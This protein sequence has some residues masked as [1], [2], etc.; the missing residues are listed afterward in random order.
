M[1]PHLSQKA[2]MIAFNTALILALAYSPASKV[3][4][5]TTLSAEV[6]Q[7]IGSSPSYVWIPD[8]YT[9]IQEAISN[10]QNDSVI[11][12]RK[13]TYN[14][15]IFID[16]PV[17]I[18]GEGIETIIDGNQ[19]DNVV[20][21]E[22][23]RV[24]LNQ[25]TI[26]NSAKDLNLQRNS[27]VFIK[28]SECTIINV[29]FTD[30]AIGLTLA[31]ACNTVVKQCIFAQN[32]YGAWLN[33]SHNNNF[34]HNVFSE[35]DQSI[36]QVV[37]NNNVFA[38][39]TMENNRMGIVLGYSTNNTITSNIICNNYYAIEFINNP[40]GN[41]L[42]QGNNISRNIWAL[43][44][45]SANYER[46][47][48]NTIEENSYGI[49][50]I[51]SNDNQIW[52]N[53]IINNAIQTNNT[54][55]QNTWNDTYYGNY[56]SDYYVEDTS[57]P[58]G[59]GDAPKTLDAQNIDYHPLL[60]TLEVFPVYEE[61][62]YAIEVISNST[63]IR[64]DFYK[65]I[66]QIN[67]SLNTKGSTDFCH[68][69]IPKNLLDA[70][71]PDTWRVFDSGTE[72]KEDLTISSNGSHSILYF[73]YDSTT[74]GILIQGTTAISEFPSLLLPLFSCLTIIIITI[75]IL[76]SRQ[77]TPITKTKKQT[78]QFTQLSEAARQKVQGD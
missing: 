19:T 48:E 7:S 39:N 52:R 68:V 27:G 36:T 70:P 56:W 47:T 54:E 43:W 25:L 28:E 64:L 6:L 9:T 72:I 18:I 75:K 30:N 10:A 67:I 74:I 20:T 38:N 32:S 71:L 21:V 50:L 31:G 66:K 59:I 26:R 44:F 23:P 76:R 35:C 61:N 78:E 46:I 60:G 51:L 45:L 34:L 62:I 57:P 2:K 4:F 73:K 58:Y 12:L 24:S 42:I 15:N 37:G 40:T 29:K 65:D 14:E 22:A 13:G 55:C 16:K 63:I 41:N 1:L 53:N 5:P 8:N 17:S 33:N 3:F 77:T 49:D 11:C 69:T